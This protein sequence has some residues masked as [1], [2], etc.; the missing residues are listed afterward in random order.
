LTALL[1][2]AYAQLAAAGLNFTATYQDEAE[3]LRRCACGP[4]WVSLDGDRLAASISLEFPTPAHLRRVCTT[5]HRPGIAW[6]QQIAVDPAYRGLGLASQLRNVAYGWARD[7]G[8]TQIG[9]DTAQPATHLVAM[10]HHWGFV[11]A[12]IIHWPGKTYDSVV[13][14]RDTPSD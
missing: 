5:A 13:L 9:L 12:E 4:C 6:L 3:T 7:H 8:A 2:R 11:D 14:T 10:Y 1:H